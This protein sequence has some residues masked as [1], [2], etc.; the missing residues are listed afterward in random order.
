MSRARHD[1]KILLQENL[2]V[3]DSFLRQ[4]IQNFMPCLVGRNQSNSKNSFGILE[5]IG[6]L[7]R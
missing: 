5:R 7:V 6:P 2:P 4:V 3:S 1:L